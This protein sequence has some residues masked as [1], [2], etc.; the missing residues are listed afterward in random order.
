MMVK[1]VEERPRPGE[2]HKRKVWPDLKKLCGHGLSREWMILPTGQQLHE[3][4]PASR[5]LHYV[6]T[7]GV[8][9]ATPFQ[10]LES[11]S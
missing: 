9:L 10:S 8:Y 6:R 2:T 1:R 4:Q 5:G 3:A 7:S 11:I